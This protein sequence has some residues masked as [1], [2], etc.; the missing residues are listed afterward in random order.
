MTNPTATASSPSHQDPHSTVE[1]GYDHCS[2][3]YTATRS[4]DTVRELL[5]LTSRLAPS[6][7]IL[8]LGCGAGVPVASHLASHGHHVTGIDISASQ[9]SLAR[10]NVP[11]N[12]T[13]LHADMASPALDFADGTF[14]A[15]VA[16]F[17]IFH[18]PKAMHADVFRRLA[19]WLKPGGY[20]LATAAASGE[21]DVQHRAESSVGNG[22]GNHGEGDVHNEDFFGAK[23]YW[24]SYGLGAYRAMLAEAGFDL[25]ENRVEGFGEGAGEM[26]RVATSAVDAGKEQHPLLFA[27]KK[28]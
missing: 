20:L 14:D 7:T 12:A 13:F 15:A 24:S 3:T 25:L 19:R 21:E 18:L 2:A 26:F 6:S 17:S 1:Q 10:V 23:M 27:R 28:A 9:I 5:L 4:Q 22:E 8:D 11:N 16:F